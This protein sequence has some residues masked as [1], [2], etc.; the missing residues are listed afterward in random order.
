[1]CLSID[2]VWVDHVLCVQACVFV[3][4]MHVYENAAA[5]F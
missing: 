1:M 2:I 3:Y 5:Y 4:V